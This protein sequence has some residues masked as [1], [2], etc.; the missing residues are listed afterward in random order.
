MDNQTTP[1]MYNFGAEYI[2]NI[3]LKVSITN[4]DITTRTTTR[5]NEWFDKYRKHLPVFPEKIEVQMTV[6]EGLLMH[7]KHPSQYTLYSYDL[8]PFYQSLLNIYDEHLIFFINAHQ[9]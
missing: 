8:I 3:N 2:A 6:S 7:F 5:K 1:S 4:G 9:T